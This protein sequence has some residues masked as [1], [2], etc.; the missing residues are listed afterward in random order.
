MTN[1]LKFEVLLLLPL[2][3][4][5]PIFGLIFWNWDMQSWGAGTRASY[6]LA[7]LMFSAI[8]GQAVVDI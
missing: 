1:L 3:V 8:M 4:V 2:V 7:S 5:Y 6:A